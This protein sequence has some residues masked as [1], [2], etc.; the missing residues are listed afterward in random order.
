M[1][2]TPSPFRSSKIEEAN[3]CD[4]PRGAVSKRRRV[5][6]EDHNQR[7]IF[8]CLAGRCSTLLEAKLTALPE[9]ETFAVPDV[10]EAQVQTPLELPLEMVA[11]CLPLFNSVIKEAFTSVER[12]RRVLA[13]RG[14][15]LMP[16]P[17]RPKAMGDGKGGGKS[18][19][20]LMPMVG[21]DDAKR[22]EKEREGIPHPTLPLNAPA[23]ES[24]EAAMGKAETTADYKAAKT[25]EGRSMT[26]TVTPSGSLPEGE[27]VL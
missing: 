13:N 22:F 2:A 16:P 11:E 17:L 27:I 25:G 8:G 15:I 4:E 26:E 6:N 12:R 19:G 18:K 20:R 14:T 24:P 1:R 9:A 7:R 5:L 21:N 3:A 10:S 23:P